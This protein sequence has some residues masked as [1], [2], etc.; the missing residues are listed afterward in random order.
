MSFIGKNKKLRKK[1]ILL[2]LEELQR[3]HDVL[4]STVSYGQQLAKIGCWLYEIQTGEVFWSEEVYNLLGCGSNCLSGNLDSFL[5]YVHQDD[6]DVVKK[7]TH[8]VETAQEYDVEYR[9][10]RADKQVKH[11][12]EKTK[13]IRDENNKPVR[14]AG[15]IQD[16][17]EQKLKEITLIEIGEDYNKA[18]QVAGVGSFKHDVSKGKS[19]AT[20]EIFNILGI[21]RFEFNDDYRNAIKLIHPDDQQKV[22][23]ELKKLMSGQAVSD[24][25][26]IIQ[27]DGAIKYI[28]SHVEPVF[29]KEGV[30]G[31]IGT[32]QDITEKN[33]LHISLQKSY[34]SLVEAERLAQ[35]GSW[36]L[37]LINNEVAFCSEEV[38]RI[39]GIS[40]EQL[41]SIDKKLLINYIHLIKN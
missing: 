22:Q 10:I 6:L 30:A 1:D 5:E 23:E 39:Y 12:R 29:D 26:R 20:D 41:Q 18:Q 4:S 28:R 13:A 19:Y 15:I 37:D 31:F 11:V 7:M 24:E 17:T 2:Q 36:E 9:I 34:R 21:S 38:C 16:I 32:M 25:F 33:L 14:M 27:K 35:I 40:K 3:E 8:F